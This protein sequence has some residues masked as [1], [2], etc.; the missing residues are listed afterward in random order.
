MLDDL[1]RALT[2]FRKYG[3]PVSP[4]HCEHDT[5]NVMVDPAQVPADDQAALAGLGFHAGDGLFYS[6]RFGS[7]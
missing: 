2:I 7:A 1:I 5:L 4:T 6:F 3:N